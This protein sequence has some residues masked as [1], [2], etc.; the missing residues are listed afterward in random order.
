MNMAQPSKGIKANQER[1]D[2]SFR[3]KYPVI[4]ARTTV[5]NVAF[6]TLSPCIYFFRQAYAH[7]DRCSDEEP[8]DYF[9]RVNQCIFYCYC[10]PCS[11]SER[12]AREVR[13]VVSFWFFVMLCSAHVGMEGI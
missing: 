2:T 9:T 7:L 3:L 6:L 4:S 13:V 1:F 5:A 10:Y 12:L 11:I 8:I